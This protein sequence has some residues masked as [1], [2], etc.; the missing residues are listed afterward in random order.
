MGG[1]YTLVPFICPTYTDL[2]N[3]L[4]FFIIIFICFNKLPINL[5]KKKAQPTFKK[6]QMAPGDNLA[7]ETVIKRQKP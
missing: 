7:L 2:S 5:Q 4:H 6:R 1:N 3:N